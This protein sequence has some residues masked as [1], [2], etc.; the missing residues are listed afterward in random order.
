MNEKDLVTE[1]RK[2][3]SLRRWGSTEFHRLEKKYGRYLF[4]PLD[5]P[6]I[7]SN[8]HEELISFYYDHARL[9]ERLKEDIAGTMDD[10]HRASFLS[11]KSM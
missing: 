9:S 6:V 1:S 8:R 3:E 2:K 10:S 4:V 5:V 11:L 7:K